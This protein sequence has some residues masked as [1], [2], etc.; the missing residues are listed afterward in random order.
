MIAVPL[1]ITTGCLK[2]PKIYFSTGTTVGLEATP[3]TTE[4]PPHIT[5]GY[6]RAEL[7]L[8]PVP[9]LNKQNTESAK[10]TP[11]S[12]P[13][14]APA[15]PPQ[16]KE[17]N[18]NIEQSP[19]LSERGCSKTP[20]ATPTESDSTPTQT[21]DAFSVLA[22]FHLAISWFG[23]TK[24]EQ[25]FATGCAATNL[26][27]GMTEE[28][29]DKRL[30][31]EAQTENQEATRLL[32]S[33]TQK[34]KNLQVKT[35]DLLGKIRLAK[36]KAEGDSSIVHNQASTKEEK[37]NAEKMIKQRVKEA[38]DIE[39]SANKLASEIQ[40]T[41]TIDNLGNAK[42]KAK[43]AADKANK[44]SRTETVRPKTQKIKVEAHTLLDQIKGR[45]RD[46]SEG[47]DTVHATL[48]TI[49]EVVDEIRG[50]ELST[51]IH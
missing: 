13:P 27:R 47:I 46:T 10:T 35:E 25:H 43:S 33:T 5:F 29:E 24:I 22:S 48:K 36:G 41:D 3:P 34:V 9:K 30:V 4:T 14:H 38:E 50:L 17:P 6:K 37:T 20:A 49:H 1:F 18:G 42:T 31:D 51:Q 21:K 16:P 7:A 11:D 44:A 8:L 2:N 39:H 15:N 28:E 12:S 32:N 19:D 45:E 26:V 40:E 23:P